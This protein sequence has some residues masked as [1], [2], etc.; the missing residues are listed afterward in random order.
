MR[1]VRPGPG[2]RRIGRSRPVSLIAKNRDARHIW[3]NLLQQLKPFSADIEFKVGEA[4]SI[5]TRSSKA[6]NETAP[7]RVGNL[8]EDNWQRASNLL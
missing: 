4:G 7:D 8:N 6:L 1:T 5:A 2:S 3:R